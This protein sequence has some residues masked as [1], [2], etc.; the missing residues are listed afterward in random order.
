M[1]ALEEYEVRLKAY[2]VLYLL[3]YLMKLVRL[4]FHTPGPLGI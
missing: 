2:L 3:K 1:A 4:S